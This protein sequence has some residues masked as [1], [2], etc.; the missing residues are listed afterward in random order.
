MDYLLIVYLSRRNSY[1]FMKNFQTISE[2]AIFWRRQNALDLKAI[3]LALLYVITKRSIRHKPLQ[4]RQNG[5]KPFLFVGISLFL[6]L[7]ALKFTDVA[8]WRDGKWVLKEE[9]RREIDRKKKEVEEAEMY[10]LLA[11]NQAI[12]VVI[13]ANR[14]KSG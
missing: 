7:V 2:R 14:E 6:L 3:Y 4:D 9:R 12:T 10:H 13:Y 1:K 11:K 8:E 5:K